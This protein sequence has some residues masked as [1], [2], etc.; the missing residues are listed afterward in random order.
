MAGNFHGAGRGDAGV[1]SGA[2][3]TIQRISGTA[4]DNPLV[5]HCLNTWALTNEIVRKMVKK[6]KVGYILFEQIRLRICSKN[7]DRCP[8]GGF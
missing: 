1:C 3:D 7:K 6:I 2:G 8:G 5:L 4:Y